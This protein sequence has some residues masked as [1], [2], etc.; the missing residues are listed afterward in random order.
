MNIMVLEITDQSFET[1]VLKSTQPVLLDFW[2]SGCKSCYIIAPTIEKLSDQ[3]TGRF[4]FCKINV[5]DNQKTASQFHVM[6]MPTLILFKD[7]KAVDTVIGAQSESAL[8][9]R[10]DD[11]L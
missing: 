1:E 7:G 3:Y 4:K 6:S 10:I 11:L 9:S 2:G 8:K 5:D